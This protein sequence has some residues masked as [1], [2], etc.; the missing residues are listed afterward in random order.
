MTGERNRQ[1]HPNKRGPCK[2]TSSQSSIE[3]PAR[4][5][6]H[7][8]PQIHASTRQPQSGDNTS[9]RRTYSGVPAQAGSSAAHAA[10]S[11]QPISGSSGQ[12]RQPMSGT[13]SAQVRRATSHG[14][15]GSSATESGRELQQRPTLQHF[16]EPRHILPE[17]NRFFDQPPDYS[18]HPPTHR[19]VLNHIKHLITGTSQQV[20]PGQGSSGER[21]GDQSSYHRRSQEQVRSKQR[22]DQR[23]SQST[24]GSLP[25]PSRNSGA[26]RAVEERPGPSRVWIERSNAS[27]PCPICF[28]SQRGKNGMMS[29][30]QSA[31]PIGMSE[32]CPHCSVSLS[33]R[34]IVKRHIESSHDKRS[35]YLHCQWCPFKSRID[36]EFEN[37]DTLHLKCPFCEYGF[38]NMRALRKHMGCCTNFAPRWYYWFPC[39]APVDYEVG[40]RKTLGSCILQVRKL[41][42]CSFSCNKLIVVCISLLPC[43]HIVEVSN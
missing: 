35:R 33:A 36:D 4:R 14:V 6:R 41:Q 10:L 3:P 2:A 26:S 23:T 11:H 28:G 24:P 7:F 43:N 32:T 37:H 5:G 25:V 27:Y 17:L 12:G 42:V 13:T 20:P 15:Y 30:L 1:S 22:S 21:R 31:H 18:P 9:A 16:S 34:A 19:R 39:H 38:S 40:R 29:H 8:Q